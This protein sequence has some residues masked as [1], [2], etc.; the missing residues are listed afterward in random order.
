MSR[1]WGFFHELVQSFAQMTDRVAK[2][3]KKKPP[4]WQSSCPVEMGAARKTRF[5]RATKG[6]RSLNSEGALNHMRIKPLTLILVLLG[7]LG[8]VGCGQGAIFYGSSWAIVNDASNAGAITNLTIPATGTGNL[9][10]VALMFNGGTYAT[11]VS[12]DA[13]NA[14]VSA[15]AKAFITDHSTEIWY[16]VNSKPGATVVTPAFADSP[17]HVEITSWEVSGIST[18]APDVTNTSSGHVTLNN[19]PGAAVSTA[20]AGDF[21]VS[22]LF[23]AESIMSGISTGNEFTNDF[24]TNGNGWAHITS[25]SVPA[26]THQASWSTSAPQGLYCSSTVAFRPAQ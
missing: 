20:Q 23:A 16:A 13:G 21:I 3:Y 4:G 5:W 26:G 12:D 1:P 15:D 14:Y 9:I 2:L 10:V 6:R 17:T 24:T 22:I 18:S 19:T 7:M 11:G 8:L 25:N